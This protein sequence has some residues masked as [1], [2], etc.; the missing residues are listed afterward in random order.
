L[1]ELVDQFLQLGPIASG[2]GDLFS[3][4]VFA[5]ARGEMLVLSIEILIPG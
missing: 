2:A 5:S 1:A 4:Q 3:E